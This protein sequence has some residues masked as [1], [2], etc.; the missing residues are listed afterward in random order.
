MLYVTDLPETEYVQF[1]ANY[2]KLAGKKDLISGLTASFKETLSFFESIPN[3]KLEYR[4]QDGK[5]TVKDILQHIIDTERIFA[6]RALRFARQ[7][8][9]VLP[10]FEEN[11]YAV[12][13]HAN[14]RTKEDL[15]EEYQT[16]RQ[17]TICLFKSF[18]KDMFLQIGKASGANMSVRAVGFV[19]IGHEKHHCQ[20][21]K[22]RYL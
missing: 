7:D 21:I 12:T 19:T 15:L 10:G 18:C 16:V 1:Y 9:T 20:V 8:E 5:W 11:Q 3:D 14:K 6:Y 2:I 13:A 17:A 22:S 4:Y